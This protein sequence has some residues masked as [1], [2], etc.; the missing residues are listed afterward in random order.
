MKVYRITRSKYADDLEGTGSK[1]FGGRWN[2]INTAC[3]YTS[4]SR[5]LAILEYSVNVGIDF[6]PRALSVCTFE[7]DESR[8]YHLSEVNLPG[9]WKEIPAPLSTK[10]LG[11][12]LLQDEIAILKI[13]SIVI[14]TE[15]N[16]ILNT[17][18]EKV[19]F[20][21]LD[22]EDFIYDLRIKMNPDPV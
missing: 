5:A 7:I 6:I 8:I 13:P 14:P 12:N 22:K 3:I 18:I 10:S 11:T 19:G 9:N 16:Y 2:H 1:L 4:A 15:Y 21:L 20:K 17:Q